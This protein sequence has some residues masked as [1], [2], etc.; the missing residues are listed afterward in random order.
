MKVSIVTQALAALPYSWS[1]PELILGSCSRVILVPLL[2]MCTLPRDDPIIQG[3]HW[4]FVVSALLGLTNGLFGSLP[5]ILAAS[6]VAEN[7]REM[8]GKTT[9]KIQN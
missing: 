8:A 5:M 7:E 6:N 4:A 1:N 2:I 9:D 3:L